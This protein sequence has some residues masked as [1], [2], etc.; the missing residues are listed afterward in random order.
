MIMEKIVANKN[1]I[2]CKECIHIYWK[3]SSTGIC[4]MAYCDITNEPTIFNPEFEQFGRP[5]GDFKCKNIETKR[6]G[7]NV[8]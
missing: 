6:R 4:Q 7:K 1:F 3:D 5:G 2:T 8:S